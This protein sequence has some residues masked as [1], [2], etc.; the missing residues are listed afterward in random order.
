[1]RINKYLASCGLGSRRKCEQMVLD[2]RVS[3]NGKTICS[4]SF[5]VQDK[6]QICLDGAP[7]ETKKFTYVMLFKPKG[8]VTTKSD[9]KGRKTVMDLLP[10]EWQ[11]LNPVGRLDY[12]TEGLLLFTNDGML[13]NSLTH[14]SREIEKT[15][16]AK[17]EGE[18][19][20]SE[21]AVLRAGVV[22]DGKRTAPAKVKVTRLEKSRVT[23]ELIIHEGRNRQIRKMFEAIGKN[24]I[25]LKRVG[26]GPIALG[27][28]SRGTARALR[29]K[30]IEALM[31]AATE[32]ELI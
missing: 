16:V 24:V 3:V 22:I 6:M 19:K 8:F 28:L 14:P 25:F 30:E 32:E 9:E 29:P 26:F 23:L 17:I 12:D 18:I 4:L 21:L 7:I 2:G 10:K 1:M 31:L 20:E 13:A 27:G 5:D 11:H 15:Y